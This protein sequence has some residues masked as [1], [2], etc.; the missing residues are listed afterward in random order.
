MA[1]VD[2]DIATLLA[3]ML[4]CGSQPTNITHNTLRDSK[5]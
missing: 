1:L 4:L 5:K 3:D 2:A